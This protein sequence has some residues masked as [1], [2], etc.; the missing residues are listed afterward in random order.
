MIFSDPPPPPPND[1]PP[2]KE[3]DDTKNLTI[4]EKFAQHRKNPSCAG[5]HAKIDSLGFSLE[6]FD[7][8]GRWRTRYEN[9]REVD[10]SG[11]LLKKYD[12][13]GI[14]DLKAALVKEERR[15]ARAFSAHLLRFAAARTLTPADSLVVDTIV[16]KTELDHWKLKSLLREVILSDAFLKRKTR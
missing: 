8:T 16:E 6:N 13:A 9:D 1:V 15:L 4:R 12:F 7:V 10:D 5:C 2:L 3:E 11:T 14:V